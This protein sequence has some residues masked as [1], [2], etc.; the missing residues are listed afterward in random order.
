MRRWLLTL[1]CVLSLVTVGGQC[2]GS[3]A[4]A[5]ERKLEVLTDSETEPEPAPLSHQWGKNRKADI[6]KCKAEGGIPVVVAGVLASEG[7][8]CAQ[9]LGL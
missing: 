1:A 9:P 3:L 6:A 2:R 5:P 4:Q 8:G 7:I